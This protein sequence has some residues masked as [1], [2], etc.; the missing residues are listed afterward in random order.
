MLVD[1]TNRHFVSALQSRLHVEAT[2]RFDET[3]KAA[4][5]AFQNKYNAS[6]PPPP[7]W[8]RND[9]VVDTETLA[10]IRSA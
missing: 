7:R 2:G 3:T 4:V 1:V 5:I 6:D 9:G 10:G 8:L